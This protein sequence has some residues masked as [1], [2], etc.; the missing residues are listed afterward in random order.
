M[1]FLDEGV[2]GIV[3]LNSCSPDREMTDGHPHA[4]RG[5]SHPDRAKDSELSIKVF[6]NGPVS[7]FTALPPP[8]ITGFRRDAAVRVLEKTRET[9]VP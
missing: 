8:S 1:M 2:N 4:A 3:L 6:K 7:Y 5:A 9:K